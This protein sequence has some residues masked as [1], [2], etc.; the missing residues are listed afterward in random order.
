MI[1]KNGPK[2]K[3]TVTAYIADIDLTNG[4][5]SIDDAGIILEINVEVGEAAPGC[6]TFL[7]DL[8]G[9]ESL[10]Y[11][12]LD[13]RGRTLAK[14]RVPAGGLFGKLTL[15]PLMAEAISKAVGSN[16]SFRLDRMVPV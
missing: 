4:L 9:T 11:S 14:G 1:E 3:K 8:R 7:V 5:R 6:N 2:P 15:A 13:N 12:I 10:A 16:Q